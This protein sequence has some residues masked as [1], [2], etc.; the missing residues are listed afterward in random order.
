MLVFASH[1]VW[2][3]VCLLLYRSSDPWALRDS[4]A[5]P[6]IM[7]QESRCSWWM[8]LSSIFMWIL[9]KYTQDMAVTCQELCILNLLLFPKERFPHK[10]K[11]MMDSVKLFFFYILEWN[12]SGFQNCCW[13]VHPQLALH[14]LPNLIVGMWQNDTSWAHLSKS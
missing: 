8:L 12:E 1:L 10:L 14:L 4:P 7:L 3:K 5:L 13:E 9:R 2:D 6:S 11:M